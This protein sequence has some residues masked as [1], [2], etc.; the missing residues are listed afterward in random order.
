MLVKYT[1][2]EEPEDFKRE[3]ARDASKALKISNK[4]NSL[5]F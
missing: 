5:L 1:R 4:I 2:L 3:L